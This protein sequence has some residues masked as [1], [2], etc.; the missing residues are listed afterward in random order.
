MKA[1]TMVA[2]A[3]AAMS[4]FAVENEDRVGEA[5]AALFKD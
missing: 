4:L 3:L 2:T 5:V 1:V